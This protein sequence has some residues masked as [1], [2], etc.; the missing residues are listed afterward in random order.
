[1][2]TINIEILDDGIISIKTTEISQVNHIS[3]DDLL[4]MLTKEIG[5]LKQKTKNEHVFW[6]DKAV[7]KGGKIIQINK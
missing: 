4:E 3:A 5:S 7:Q 1:M 6:K 2:D